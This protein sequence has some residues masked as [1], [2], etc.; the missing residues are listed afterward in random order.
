[1]NEKPESDERPDPVNEELP[2]QTIDVE[3]GV[4]VER[5]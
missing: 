1:M 3:K 2:V 5:K 4:S